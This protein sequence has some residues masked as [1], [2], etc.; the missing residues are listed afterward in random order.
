MD[1]A[2]HLIERIT[3]APTHDRVGVLANELL[4]EFQLGYP[5]DDLEQLLKNNDQD[6]VATGAWITSELGERCRPLL[7]DV[8]PLL[9]HPLQ[10][11][12]FWALDCLFWAP[13]K[14]G[15]YLARAV[16]LLDD[17]ETGIRRKV[18]NLLFRF[19]REE[20]E[21]AYHCV[22][23]YGLSPS[24]SNGLSWL[25][26]G[27]AIDPVEVKRALGSPDPLFR[28]F[29]AAAAARIH[30]EHKEPLICASQVDDPDIS[31]FANR[32]LES[33]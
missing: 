24:M 16:R 21:A 8:L 13:P 23:E 11:I 7:V 18:L 28:R 3:S 14:N 31:K 4:R 19:S 15:C 10:R 32:I 22:G 20:L 17:P 6:V 30:K 29:G 33:Q 12:R 26:S 9:A 2:K 1:Y 27:D 25:L 5:L